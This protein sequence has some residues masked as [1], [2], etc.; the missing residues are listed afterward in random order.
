MKIE[1]RSL[2][3]CFDLCALLLL[4]GSLTEFLTAGSS[5]RSDGALKFQLLMIMFFCT[6]I[7][8]VFIFKNIPCKT[9]FRAT[10]PL[11]FLT[12]LALASALWSF[13]PFLS[14]RRS[15][16]LLLSVLFAYSICLYYTRE[17][18]AKLLLLLSF[19]ILFTIVLSIIFGQAY[20]QD[21]EHFGSLKG[22]TGHKNSLGKYLAVIIIVL[23]SIMLT[24]YK[25][26]IVW[27]LGLAVLML[28]LTESKT[29]LA[30]CFISIISVYFFRFQI[31]GISP[32]KSLQS[33]KYWKI[34]LLMTL[35]VIICGILISF[36]M[37]S[38]TVDALGRDLTFSGRNKIWTYAI[39]ISKDFYILGAGYKTF[40]IDKLTWDFL[41][42]NPYWSADK[43][44]ANGHNGYL[45][46]YLELGLLGLISLIVFIFSFFKVLF[47]YRNERTT[48][49]P[50]PLMAG[51]L[52]AFSLIYNFF[53]TSFLQNRP[54]LVWIILIIVYIKMSIIPNEESQ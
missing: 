30:A 1:K 49:R 7:V 4:T 19:L 44:T 28:I 47:G 5:N 42:Q 38:Y 16:S 54:D 13:E 20:H 50:L 11:L 39:D 22:F 26:R 35:A 2:W 12:A 8:R 51:P 25:K 34:R 14:A 21:S 52:L 29:S 32:I 31:Y 48:L 41:L 53:E 23:Y 10:V 17:E 43:I 37:F 6:T 15:I 40:W 27:V 36:A 3:F 45:D 18:I 9:V 46:I 24:G 33:V